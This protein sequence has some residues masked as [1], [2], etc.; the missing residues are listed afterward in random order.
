[1]VRCVVRFT[2]PHT[3][4]PPPTM[5]PLDTVIVILCGAVGFTLQGAVGFGM[6]MLGS[7]I[8]IL[9][10]TRLV[11]GPVLASTMVFTAMMTLREHRAI[12]LGGL[13][14]AVGGRLAATVPAALV[15]AVLPA[16]QLSLVFGI[17]VLL[18]VAISVSGLSVEPRPAAL[19]VGGA[20]SGIMGTIASIGGPPM[21]LLY[22]HASG[23][24]VRGTLSSFFL[25]GTIT[26]LAA[27]VFVGRFGRE[28]LRL[29][30]LL[31]PGALFGFF[32]S[33]RLAT[34]LDRGY[35]RRAVLMVAAVAGFIV[36]ARYFTT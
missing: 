2:G 36:V 3:S 19:L 18:A 7:P 24:R 25:V 5:S 28:E 15:L 12:D 26:S 1:M 21:A 29:S 6:G 11:P 22:Q 13:R 35:T 4:L 10:D 14:W 23:A 31:L 17:I 20:L 27:L 32:G 34:R 16:E 33:R 9:I 8:L 30:L